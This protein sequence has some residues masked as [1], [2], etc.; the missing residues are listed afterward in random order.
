MGG[1]EAAADE[2]DV[3]DRLPGHHRGGEDPAHGVVLDPVGL[4]A[5]REGR[6]REVGGADDRPRGQVARGDRHLHR[7]GRRAGAHPQPDEH[8]DRGTHGGEGTPARQHV[9]AQPCASGGVRRR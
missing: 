1:G 8:G 9:A 2:A 4:G 5:R 6:R 7:G 3:G